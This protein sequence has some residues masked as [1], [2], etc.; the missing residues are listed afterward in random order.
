MF[1]I[2]DSKILAY[3]VDFENLHIEIEAVDEKGNKAK[4][5]FDDFF[6][7]Y[8]EDQLPGSIVTLLKVISQIL[9]RIIRSC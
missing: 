1:T 9:L 7:Y 5:L 3:Q 4:L 6:A 2:H 8:F